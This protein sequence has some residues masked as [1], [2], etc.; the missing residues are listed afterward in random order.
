MTRT[1]GRDS[2][3]TDWTIAQAAKRECAAGRYGCLRVNAPIPIAV[4][5]SHIGHV[6]RTIVV[7][8]KANHDAH[9]W[10]GR[11]SQDRRAV[12]DRVIG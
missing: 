12:G 2:R 5:H 7:D 8:V 10:A 9:M 6:G 1:V 11:P 4:R 3:Y